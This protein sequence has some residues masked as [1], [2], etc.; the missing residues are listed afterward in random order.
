[1]TTVGDDSSA[2]SEVYHQMV[3][4]ALRDELHR[5]A[6]D[7]RIP[8]GKARAWALRNMRWRAGDRDG[9]GN[10]V[11]S[12]PAPPSAAIGIA[13]VVQ[14]VRVTEELTPD[15]R[16]SRW[17]RLRALPPREQVQRAA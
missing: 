12:P 3:P 11:H 9:Y 7:P 4:S 8:A 2:Y 16:G 5:L 14:L 13:A 15:F 10:I 1:M 17:R 6:H